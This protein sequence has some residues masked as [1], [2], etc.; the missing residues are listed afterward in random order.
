[1]LS[2]F[3]FI[4]S[5]ICGAILLSLLSAL[6]KYLMGWPLMPQ[7]FAVPFV[8]GM[9]TGAVFNLYTLF[10]KRQRK[11]EEL[12][13][14]RENQLNTV[15][16]AAPIG[17][18]MV[19]DR[20]LLEVNDFFCEMTGYSREELIGQSSRIVYP[21]DDDFDYVTKYKYDQI[22]EKGVGT[23]ETRLQHKNGSIIHVILSSKPLNPDDWSQGV[24][25]TALN[26]TK[27]KEAENSLARRIV[28][29]NL[30]SKVASDFLDL[31]VD[32]IDEGLNEALMSVSRFT[33]VDRAYIFL[34][35]GNTSICDNTH[36]W[37]AENI[38]PQIHLLQSLDLQ[39][40]GTLL[41]DKLNRREPYYIPDVS[42]LPEDLPDKE[43]L[44]AQS[45]R[46]V[47]IEPM[48]LND[49]LVGFAG[50]DSVIS[51]RQ[52]SEEDIDIL[53]LFGKNVALVLE[54]KKTEEELIGAKLGAETANI[55]KSDFL[56]NMSH[57][58]R[59]PLNGIMGMLQLMHMDGLSPQ[60]D[61][62]YHFAMQSCKRLTQLLSDVLDIS[63]I[64]SGHLQ[65]VDAEFD[66][67][68]VL[69][70]AYALF[71]PVAVQK[72]VD[73]RFDVAG[74]L[75]EKLLGD[76]NRLHQIFNN[77]IGNALKFT[78][79]GSVL[80]EV[81]PLKSTQPG[82]HKILFSVTDSGIGIEDSQLES[83]FNSFTQADASRTR[84]YEGAG[85]GL[86]IVKKL[87]GLMGGNL[88]IS[89]ELEVGT[90]VHFSLEFDEA[91]PESG[92]A[93]CDQD[94]EGHSIK[95]FNVLVAEDEKVNLLTLKSFLE[96]LG[97]TVSVAVDG[98]GVIEALS[99]ESEPFD[100]IFMD[101]QMPNMGGLEA[102]VRIRAGEAGAQ[103]SDV[104]IIACTAH[105]M[106]GDKEEFLSAGMDDYLSKPTR[107]DDVKRIL[108]KYSGVD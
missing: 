66:L 14:A 36:E 6:Q 82:K 49:R 55:A 21:S 50:F 4:F 42:V 1:M 31:S 74:S 81:Y 71:R 28:F 107:I 46:S 86:A 90:S 48:Y 20:V 40:F 43:V 77:L 63:M 44:E 103:N 32:K 102:T 10:V 96:K 88:S 93:G 104:P 41:W 33:G 5:A 29:E 89:S 52:W 58:I 94:D 11:T 39:D 22:K 23:V 73:L 3:R 35:R 9:I 34:M 45:I 85:L 26:I 27:R 61:E 16:T 101:I 53:S 54:R 79:D 64:E 60:Q 69:G 99:V 7:A 65:I 105:A 56:A 92:I 72:N 17:I 8:F 30:V 13:E 75:P 19:V 78:E 24:S 91:R 84:D 57:E 59:T 76:S 38:E 62:H 80:V 106:A 87:L 2:A 47:L 18:G 68:D 70:S 98:H 100:L 67:A 97:C 15:L 25:F 12:L 37:C 83:V 108:V 51:L 95:E